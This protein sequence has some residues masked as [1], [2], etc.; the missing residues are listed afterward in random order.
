MRWEGA[1]PGIPRYGGCSGSEAAHTCSRF[2][3]SFRLMKMA[4]LLARFLSA[5]RM[6]AV[7]EGQCGQQAGPA[8][9]LL[10]ET[11]LTRVVGLPDRLGTR[12]QQETLAAF[13]PQNYFPLLG[14]EVLRV[15][16]AV[17]DS[18]RG[19]GPSSDSLLEP[20]SA[21]SRPPSLA[22]RDSATSGQCHGQVRRYGLSGAAA[23]HL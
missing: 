17:V 23:T 14:E 7:M 3:P 9:H 13:F 12:L 18:L 20:A 19:E 5:G 21:L 16:Q 8:S 6:A 22:S 10:Q 11:L 15:L 2:S 4:R 1:C